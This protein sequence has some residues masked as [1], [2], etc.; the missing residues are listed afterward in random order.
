VTRKRKLLE[1]Q[2][3]GKRRMRR[4]GKIEMPQEAFTA[5]LKRGGSGEG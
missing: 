1:K 3:E 4:I 2:K 5:V